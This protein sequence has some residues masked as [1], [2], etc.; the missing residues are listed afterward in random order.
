MSEHLRDAAINRHYNS[1]EDWPEPPPCTGCSGRGFF[2]MK[3]G[4]K[5]ERVECPTCEG[6]GEGE[7]DDLPDL[8]SCAPTRTEE[9]EGDYEEDF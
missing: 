6:S 8:Y 3:R 1:P 2:T 7:Q 4:V 5:E 9:Y